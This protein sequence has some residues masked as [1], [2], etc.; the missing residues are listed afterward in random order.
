[1]AMAMALCRKVHFEIGGKKSSLFFLFV[2]LDIDCRKLEFLVSRGGKVTLNPL[3]HDR[4]ILGLTMM[5][6]GVPLNIRC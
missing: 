5:P 1:M 2:F 4:P 3:R 6:Y